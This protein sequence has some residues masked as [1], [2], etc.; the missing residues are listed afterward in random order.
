MII[1]R[2][3]MSTQPHLHAV[4]IM[5]ESAVINI[6]IT[7]VAIAGMAFGSH[8]GTCALQIAIPCQVSGYF[9]I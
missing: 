3:E 5:L 6:P 1:S 9:N 8:L 4:G 7:I 2:V